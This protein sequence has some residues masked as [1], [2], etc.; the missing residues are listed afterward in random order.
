M[1][2]RQRVRGSGN[3]EIRTRPN[4]AMEKC[5]GMLSGEN[6]SDNNVFIFS[7]HRVCL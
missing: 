3:Q 5:G 4:N 1:E 6:V 7:D 2:T